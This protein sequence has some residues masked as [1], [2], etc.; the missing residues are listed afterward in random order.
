MSTLNASTYH[1]KSG[2]VT[3]SDVSAYVHDMIADF[4]EG[5]RGWSQ[6]AGT[7]EIGEA[8]RLKYEKAGVLLAEGVVS[9]GTAVESSALS[10]FEGAEKFQRT[11]SN[12]N[13]TI[14]QHGGKK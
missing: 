6:Y 7:D 13:H 1:M 11:Q 14:G 8:F 12:V 9:Y 10:V 2:S 4:R 3:T 5:T